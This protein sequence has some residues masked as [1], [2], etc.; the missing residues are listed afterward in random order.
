MPLVFSPIFVADTKIVV[1]NNFVAPL[2]KKQLFF[3]FNTSFFRIFIRLYLS[4]L[5]LTLHLML[6]NNSTLDPQASKNLDKNNRFII[7]D[8]SKYFYKHKNEIEFST[9][10]CN[11]VEAHLKGPN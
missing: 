6:H 11:F 9:F 7:K 10:S 3:R 4:D 2:S 1:S 8:I 5:W